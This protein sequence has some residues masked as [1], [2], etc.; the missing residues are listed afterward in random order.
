M[1]LED[2]ALGLDSEF[3]DLKRVEGSTLDT[4]SEN[5]WVQ[6]LSD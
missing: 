3:L 1:G 6:S 5:G 2:L 4:T